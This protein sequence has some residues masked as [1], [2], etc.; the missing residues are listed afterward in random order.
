MTSDSIA[1]RL[2]AKLTGRLGPRRRTVL[3]YSS[4]A[5]NG[6]FSPEAAWY[7]SGAFLTAPKR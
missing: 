6:C 2:A 5:L 3:D 4:A 7:F 1:V